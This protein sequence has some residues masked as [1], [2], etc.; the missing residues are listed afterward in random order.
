MAI[1][2]ESLVGETMAICYSVRDW[3]RD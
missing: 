2:G 1:Y 3:T